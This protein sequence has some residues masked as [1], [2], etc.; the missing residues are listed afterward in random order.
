VTGLLKLTKIIKTGSIYCFRASKM[1][2]VRYR[3][4]NQLNFEQLTMTT[5]QK[6]G[7]EEG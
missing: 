5:R 3:Q 1:N 4:V 7:V 2:A 6:A